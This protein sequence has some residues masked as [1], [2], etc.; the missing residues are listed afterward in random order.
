MTGNDS[1]IGGAGNDI[2]RGGAGSDI[3]VVDS[4][5]DIVEDSGPDTD[6]DTVESRL[7]SYTLGAGIENLVLT[8]VTKTGIGNADENLITGN[9]AAND[10]RGMAGDDTLLGAAG[11]DTLIG[12]DGNDLMDGG[13]EIDLVS[14]A[15]HAAGV[16]VH[17]GITSAQDTG[18]A[19]VDRILNVENLTGTGFDDTL[20]GDAGNNV[21]DG[22]LGIDTLSYE[23]ATGGVTVSL[24]LT[25]AQNTV[26]RRHG[27]GEG[28]REPH[29]L[30]LCRPAHRLDRS[31]CAEG[32][33]RQ[34]H[35]PGRQRQRHDRRRP[36]R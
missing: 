23:H 12:G 16:N 33:W 8:G 7:A 14:Y 6:V 25:T 26:G 21:L 27:H 4:L 1:L 19:G 30:R 15:G 29:R 18:G 36:G 9:T 11:A 31:Q 24:L 2:M 5:L 10:L 35:D 22:G 3:Y 34:R 32:P 28:V 20:G 17:L 13:S